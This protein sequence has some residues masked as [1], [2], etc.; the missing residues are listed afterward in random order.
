VEAALLQTSKTW[1]AAGS[2]PEPWRSPTPTV[3]GVSGDLVTTVAIG[4]AVG[5]AK[6]R[7]IV[8][9]DSW[10][11]TVPS[12]RH[13]TWTAFGYDAPRARAPQAVLLVVPSFVDNGVDVGEARRAVLTAREM[14][15]ARSVSATPDQLSIGLPTGVVEAVG[16]TACTLTRRAL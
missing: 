4:P 12:P 6:G 9:L 15:R 5:K 10:G 13:T 2:D 3:D 14:A 11:E 8:R 1:R 7:G 16:S